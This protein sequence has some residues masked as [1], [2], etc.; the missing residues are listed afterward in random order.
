MAQSGCSEEDED[1]QGDWRLE[2]L[3]QRLAILGGEHDQAMGQQAH[4]QAGEH[5]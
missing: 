1:E 3:L 4:V 5:P 2:S